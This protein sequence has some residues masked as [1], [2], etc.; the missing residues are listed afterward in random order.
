M[1][2]TDAGALGAGAALLGSGGGGDVRVGVL[3]LRHALA[4]RAT[5]PVVPAA[6]LPPDALVVHVGLVGSPDVVAERPPDGADFARAVH[7]VAAAV[8][9]PAAAVG[10]IEIGG[11]NALTP[12]LAAHAT[13]LPVVDGDVMGRAFPLISQSTLAVAGEPIT[14]LAVVGAAAEEVLVTAPAPAAER[15][16]RA[17]VAALGGAAA[18]AIYPATA[19]ALVTHGVSGSLGLCLRLGAQLA[20]RP[21]GPAELARRIGASVLCEG[22]VDEVRPGRDH[23]LGSAT[24]R[25]HATGAVVRLDLLDEYLALTVDGVP[26]A[27]VPDVLAVVEPVTLAPIPPARLRPGQP[28]AVLHLPALARWPAA[29]AAVVGPAA[30]GLDLDLDLAGAWT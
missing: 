1:G 4:D 15:L 12:L 28:L 26:V 18:F 16:L 27:A 10:V 9:R 22:R 11:L 29:A 25:D 6:A 14:P 2:A 20:A 8:G 17:T 19:A 3:A 30:F 24:V 5:V 21:A 23:V 7:A 13:G